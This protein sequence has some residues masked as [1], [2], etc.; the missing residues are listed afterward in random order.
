MDSPWDTKRVGP[1]KPWQCQCGT[2]NEP[3]YRYCRACNTPVGYRILSSFGPVNSDTE[4]QGKGS[5]MAPHLAAHPRCPFMPNPPLGDWGKSQ[6]RQQPPII[7]R[8]HGTSPAVHRGRQEGH[9]I[10]AVPPQARANN[11]VEGVQHGKGTKKIPQGRSMAT[12]FCY[13]VCIGVGETTSRKHYLQ[14]GA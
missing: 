3:C 8:P 12:Q 11:V 9:Y 5:R 10:G 6:R 4:G 2:N 1:P 14:R 13:Q 7:W